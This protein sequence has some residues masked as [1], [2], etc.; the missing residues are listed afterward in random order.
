MQTPSTAR[1]RAWEEC[2]DEFFGATVPATVEALQPVGRALARTEEHA[3][4]EV[5]YILAL[6]EQLYRGGARAWTSSPLRAHG[7]KVDWAEVGGARLPT[8][9][10]GVPE[11]VAE[12][13]ARLSWRFYDTQ[14]DLM[15]GQAVLN[16]TFAGSRDVGGADADLIVDR[17]L[18]DVKT[19]TKPRLE[20]RTL[21]QLL[22]YVLL[23]YDGR[24]DVDSV[25]IYLARQ[26]ILVRWPL[27]DLLR[28]LSEEVAPILAQLRA[29][30][31]TAI[32]SRWVRNSSARF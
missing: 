31:R 6:F 3:L 4:A 13:V 27:E 32:G 26:G 29:D 18:I 1:W 11:L 28:M 24:Y 8:S 10:V 16:P 22:G 19:T 15:R 20:A 21:Y 7:P 23:D 17:C 9:P 30:F 25:G 2:L 12:D 5:C 14:R